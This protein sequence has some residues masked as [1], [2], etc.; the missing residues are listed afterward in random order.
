MSPHVAKF[1]IAAQA[2]L[3]M[4]AFWGGWL[5]I[6]L[7]SWGQFEM[8][9]RR[10]PSQDLAGLVRYLDEHHADTIELGIPRERIPK[11]PEEDGVGRCSILWTR[12]AGTDQLERARRFRPL[13]SMVLQEGTSSRRWLIWSLDRPVG[14]FDA[15]E[16][17]RRLAYAFGA[18]QK[19]GNPD[20][21]WLA[22][23]GTCVRSGSR[24]VPVRVTRLSTDS[25]GPQITDRL[26]EPPDK[27]AWMAG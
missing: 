27:L 22:A 8:C 9:W 10:G 16:R 12:V 6:R 14:Y 19:F 24:P 20:E 4:S 11:R 17:N 25:Y 15:V 3:L 5:P 2:L 13:P 18:V 1:D 21:A 26:K 23:P 7:G